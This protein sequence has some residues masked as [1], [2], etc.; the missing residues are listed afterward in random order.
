MIT[1]GPDVAHNRSVDTLSWSVEQVHEADRKQGIRVTRAE[2][3][4]LTAS[5]GADDS[6]ERASCSE[7]WGW[8]DFGGDGVP[9][10]Q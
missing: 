10:P 3:P 2:S 4:R 8:L 5:R 1:V 9:A 6:L 7:A